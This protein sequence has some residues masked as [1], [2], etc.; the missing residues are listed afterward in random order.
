VIDTTFNLSPVAIA[1]ALKCPPANV[2]R[3]W[4]ALRA[5]CMENGLTDKASIIAV[6][7][8]VGTEVAS[9]EPINEFGDTPY[10]SRNY[11]G[12]A[13]LG[14]TH[15]GDGARYH[16]RG[17]IQLTGRANYRGYEQ[18]LGIPLEEQPELAL[19]ATVAAR[20]LG[21]YFKDRGIAGDARKGDW[22]A[23]RRKVNGGLNGWDRFSALVHSLEHAHNAKAPAL[24]EGAIGP[25]V[26]QLKGLLL[27]WGKTHPLP[28]PI[29]PTPLFGPATTEAVRAFQE[30]HG[31]QA[32][33]KVG[34][35]TWQA[36][37]AATKSTVKH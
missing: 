25:D 24:V 29:Q 6:L 21:C 34:E 20:V 5:A 36:L 35:K 17:F 30:T 16:G 2:N 10:F 28:K 18:K 11:D 32:T 14:N 1:G 4:P 33:G 3:Y 19:D 27:T 12:R 37:D 15:P 22:K 26:L 9:F 31:I 23:V 8:T 13:D 7:A